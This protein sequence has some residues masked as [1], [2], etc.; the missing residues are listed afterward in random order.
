M[1]LPPQEERL[2]TSKQFAE[3][4]LSISLATFKRKR[5]SLS[6][7][8]PK[9]IRIGRCVRWRLSEVLEFIRS[10]EA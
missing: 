5:A 6:S 8:L 3:D 2:I 7:G 9:P 10:L 4:Y 1:N